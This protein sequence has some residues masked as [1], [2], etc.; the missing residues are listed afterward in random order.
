MNHVH[1]RAKL[2]L[3]VMGCLI[4]ATPFSFAAAA[5][6]GLV[7]QERQDS[8]PLQSVVQIEAG[9]RLG[10]GFFINP[11]GMA[12]TNQHVVGSSKIVNVRLNDGRVVK[13]HVVAESEKLDLAVVRVELLN[14]PFLQFYNGA[15]IKAGSEISI[16]G[17]P[18]GLSHSL[19]H[20]TVSAESRKVENR[21]LMQIDGNVNPGLSG[22]PV[23]NR[24]SDVIGIT[25]ARVENAQGIGF[26][27]KLPDIYSFTESHGVGLVSKDV[28]HHLVPSATLSSASSSVVH[29]PRLLLVLAIAS[30][31]M[32]I[33][34]IL[35]WRAAKNHRSRVVSG[36]NLTRLPVKPV[37]K[38]N[39]DDVQITLK[40]GRR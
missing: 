34:S 14:T 18:E 33:S 39:F 4:F 22:G 24:D 37:K 6:K 38:E 2:I 8:S 17:S 15:E 10:S 32:L 27:I 5:T 19:I 7:A 12:L 36:Q 31:L 3:G 40:E 20:A 9:A 28:K 35:F 11:S 21:D 13:G 29:T 25:V 26:A 16:A 1:T 23:L 30:V